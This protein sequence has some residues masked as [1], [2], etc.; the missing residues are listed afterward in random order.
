MPIPHSFLKET[1]ATIIGLISI[2][3][4]RNKENKTVCNFETGESMAAPKPSNR[5]RRYS[6]VRSKRAIRQ[7][8]GVRETT[9]GGSKLYIIIYIIFLKQQR[10]CWTCEPPVQPASSHDRLPYP[11]RI[12]IRTVP[13]PNQTIRSVTFRLGGAEAASDPPRLVLTG[14]Q[15]LGLPYPRGL[16]YVE[17]L[18]RKVALCG[19]LDSQELLPWLSDVCSNWRLQRR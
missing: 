10:Q 14:Y 11:F 12:L 3:I 16:S 6:Y 2:A 8:P 9:V 7:V 13:V 1:A 19:S 17:I 18:G 15:D 5:T 4:L